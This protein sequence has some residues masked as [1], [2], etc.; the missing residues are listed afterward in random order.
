MC[1]TPNLLGPEGIDLGVAKKHQRMEVEE[2]GDDSKERAL[3]TS[4]PPPPDGVLG[5]II[6]L[7][8]TKDASC[9]P[10]LAK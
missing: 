9:V 10:T 2:L 5:D 1:L 7:V 8:P 3:I 4:A 6:S